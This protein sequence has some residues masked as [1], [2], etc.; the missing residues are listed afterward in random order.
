[1]QRRLCLLLALALATAPRLGAAEGLLGSGLVTPIRPLNRDYVSLFQSPAPRVS[2][3]PVSPMLPNAAVIPAIPRPELP[4][5][6]GTI[7]SGAMCRPALASAEVRYGIPSGLLQAIG[8]VESGQRDE[9]T[10]T[11]QPWPWTINAEGEP[12][13]F[14]TKQQAVAWVRQAQGRGMRS[15]DTGCAQVN[16]MHHPGAFASL[17]DAFDPMANADYAAHFLKELRDTKAGGNWM[18]AVGYYHSQTPEL[19][20]AY[21]QQ[22]QAAVTSQAAGPRPM[23][24]ALASAIGPASPFGSAGRGLLTGGA[25][26]EPTQLLAAPTGT[27]GR[28]LDAYRAAPIQM[29]GAIG[30]GPFTVRR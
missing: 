13:F 27:V 11:R 2:Q 10:G 30:P 8:L 5:P 17:E 28:G 29:A 26:P 3:G 19:A 1:M 7:A 16:L 25:R 4:M 24:P 23:V 15:V 20:E 9:A 14:A 18:T 12:H 22:V 6:G 21:R